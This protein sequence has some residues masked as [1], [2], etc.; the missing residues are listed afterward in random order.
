MMDAQD[1]ERIVRINDIDLKTEMPTWRDRM[2]AVAA[3]SFEDDDTVAVVS[4]AVELAEARAK[5]DAQ[6]VTLTPAMLARLVADAQGNGP[7]AASARAALLS[8]G[9]QA[10]GQ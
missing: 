4:R 5:P 10:D 8:I 2:V 3:E 1:V 6:T 9:A 7:H